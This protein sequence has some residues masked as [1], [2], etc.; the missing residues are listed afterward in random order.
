MQE[1][2]KKEHSTKMKDVVGDLHHAY[3]TIRTGRASVSLVDHIKVAAYGSEMPLIQLASISTPDARSIAIQP[4]D[5]S[6]IGAIEKAL[7][8][9]ELGITP[10]N[11]GKIVRLNIPQLTEDRRKDLVKLARKYAE[12]HRVSIRQVRHHLIDAVKALEKS[13]DV[14]EDDSHRLQDEAQKLTDEHIAQVDKELERKEAE[15][16]EV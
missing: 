10:S 13:G 2:L 14:S 16:M 9:S 4:F 1:Q 6:Q 5:P 3:E 11:D 15:I 12:E 8:A 7:I